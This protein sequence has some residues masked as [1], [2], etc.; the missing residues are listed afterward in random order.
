MDWVYPVGS[1]I[2]SVNAAFDPNRLYSH[3]TWE[4]FAKGRALVGVDEADAAFST[5]EKT[6]GE[7]THKL[8]V[9]EMPSHGEH[10][11]G[12]MHYNG[13]TAVYLPSSA[14]TAYGSTGRGWRNLNGGEIYPAGVYSGGS[15]AHNNL[16][17]YAAVYCWKR[18]A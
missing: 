14:M 12:V 6:G 10:I 16:Q 4:R 3:Q 8:A 13:N 18:T 15:A 5:A 7:K 1:V 9:S 11:P 17:P 2:A